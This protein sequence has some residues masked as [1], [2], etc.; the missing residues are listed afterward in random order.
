[1][2]DPIKA[3]HRRLFL[4][5]QEAIGHQVATEQF[6]DQRDLSERVA[7]AANQAID[8]VDELAADGNPHKQRVAVIMKD[9]VVRAV[10]EHFATGRHEPQEGGGA[11]IEAD[12]FPPGGSPPS[13]E[14]SL[15]GS[16]AKALPLASSEP[17]KRGRGRPPKHKG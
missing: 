12:P 11:A 15:P 16:L 7:R 2:F 3:L 8:L 6:V 9:T 1:M 13:S 10:E 4:R 5:F 14:T 17:P